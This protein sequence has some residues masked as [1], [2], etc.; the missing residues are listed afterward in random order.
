M[1]PFTAMFV[2]GGVLGVFHT[3]PE[4]L[5]PFKC[6]RRPGESQLDYQMRE[7]HRLDAIMRQMIANNE[8]NAARTE[9]QIRRGDELLK[10]A[11]AA[12]TKRNADAVALKA[13]GG[14]IADHP[15]ASY[16]F[17]PSAARLEGD[18]VR[19]EALEKAQKNLE[20]IQE[21]LP[22]ANAKTKRV[23]AA[24]EESTRQLREQAAKNEKK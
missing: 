3:R 7:F 19:Q 11:Q 16:T 12:E 17:R 2:A 21:E 18:R 1:L 20:R 6:E 14:G 15:K 10:V 8:R 23:I 24:L 4:M 13:V 9:E 5:L 22:A